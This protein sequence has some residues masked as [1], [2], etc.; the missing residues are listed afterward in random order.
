M[1]PW[2]VSSL[3]WR[4]KQSSRE[5]ESPLLDSSEKQEDLLK[6]IAAGTATN[7]PGQGF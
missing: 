4:K 3:L 7:R 2:R 6:K 1:K 5:Q